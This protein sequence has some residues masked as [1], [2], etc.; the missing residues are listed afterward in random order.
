MDNTTPTSLL[1]PPLPGYTTDPSY[2]RNA[3][4]YIQS[5]THTNNISDEAKDVVRLVQHIVLAGIQGYSPNTCHHE[6]E[7]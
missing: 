4:T 2:L 6:V 7:K 3:E 5:Y 1:L